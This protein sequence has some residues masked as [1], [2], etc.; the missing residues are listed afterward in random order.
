M[1]AHNTSSGII[2][3]RGLQLA[4]VVAAL[5]AFVGQLATEAYFVLQQWPNNTNLSGFYWIFM[6][7]F[8]MPVVL[9]GISCVFNPRKGITLNIIFENMLITVTGLMVFGLIDLVIGRLTFYWPIGSDGLWSWFSWNIIE[10]LTVAILFTCLLWRLRV[11]K[12]WQ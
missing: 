12:R 2:I 7:I 11:V 9:F 6:S 8:V 3:P 1:M 10:G 4:F 5:L